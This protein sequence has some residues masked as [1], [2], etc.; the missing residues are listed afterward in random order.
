MNVSGTE[1][2]ETRPMN[3]LALFGEMVVPATTGS[4]ISVE[5]DAE[6]LGED[7]EEVVIVAAA[8]KIASENQFPD[9]SLHILDGQLS[10]LK[11]SLARIKFYLGDIDDLIPR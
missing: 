6:F 4:N 11:E 5:D 3:V 7:E 9:Q 1:D 8:R 10:S 2:L